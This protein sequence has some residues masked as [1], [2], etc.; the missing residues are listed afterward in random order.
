MDTL[1][2]GYT[3][4][5]LIQFI[6]I[7]F[8]FFLHEGSC[9]ASQLDTLVGTKKTKIPALWSVGSRKVR[10]CASSLNRS[11]SEEGGDG[12]GLSACGWASPAD[13]WVL[14]GVGVGVGCAFR[15]PL[16]AWQGTGPLPHIRS[17]EPGNFLTHF[18]RGREPDT[19]L[20]YNCQQLLLHKA[21]F[22]EATL[23]G[24]RR[25]MTFLRATSPLHRGEC[26]VPRSDLKERTGVPAVAQ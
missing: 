22:T 9:Y 15:S 14:S 17:R 18:L 23:S 24:K 26:F 7:F 13:G 4:G 10:P 2:I 12:A 11:R 8:F 3:G 1:V 20:L 19:T 16:A 5:L 25:K 21:A 6:Q